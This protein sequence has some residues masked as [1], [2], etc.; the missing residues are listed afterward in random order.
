MRLL[1]VVLCFSTDKSVRIFYLVKWLPS[2]AKMKGFI[3]VLDR[4]APAFRSQGR[5]QGR[6]IRM[7]DQP[8]VLAAPSLKI[9]Q[10][11]YKPG[12]ALRVPGG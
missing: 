6:Q 2:N 3:I 11:L 1:G 10:S 9:K 4:V 7:R 5:F 8:V 12:Q